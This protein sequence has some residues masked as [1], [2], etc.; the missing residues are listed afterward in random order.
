MSN[1]PVFA[2]MITGLPEA[3]VPIPGVRAYLFQGEDKQLVFM[4]FTEDVDVP[5]HSHAAQWG[6]V[7][8]GEITLTIGGET[9]T[10]R[11]GDA[12]CVP[13]DVPH[14]ARIA[15]GSCLQDMFDQPDRYQSK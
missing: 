8:K 11:P 6:A 12:Y 15:A 9:K 2:D 1:E 4:E 14:R 5:E 10:Y 7:L 13:A 3:D